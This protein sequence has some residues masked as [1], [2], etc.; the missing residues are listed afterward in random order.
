MNKLLV[1]NQKDRIFNAIVLML[2]F[3]FV[4]PVFLKVEFYNDDYVYKQVAVCGFSEAF[5][6][7]VWHIKNFNGRTL[8]HILAMCFLR[9]DAGVLI[10]KALGATALSAS[11]CLMAKIASC[12]KKNYTFET[13]VV[14]LLFFIIDASAWNQSIYWLTG[15]FNYFV[16]M[17][18]F[19]LLVWITNHKPENKLLY[20]FCIVCGATTEQI[21]MVT[22]GYLFLRAIDELV[23]NK[24]I[25]AKKVTQFVLSVLGY[26]T[27]VFAPGTF[28]R[29]EAQETTVNVSYINNLFVIFQDFL[30]GNISVYILIYPI[31]IISCI[32]IYRYRNTNSLTKKFFKQIIFFAAVLLLF[33]LA[34]KGFSFIA[35]N[36]NFAENILQTIQ[37]VLFIIWL[38][39]VVMFFTTLMLAALLHYRETKNMIPL[40]MLVLGFGSLIMMCVSNKA[41]YRNCMPMFFSLFIFIAYAMRDLLGNFKMREKY[42]KLK[43]KRKLIALSLMV[44][45]L[46]SGLHHMFAAI[47]ALKSG[48]CYINVIN[49]TKIEMLSAEEID[50]FYQE[51]EQA[52]ERYYENPDSGWNKT[53]DS[54]DFLQY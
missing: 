23:K 39:M 9:T 37:P 22:V 48:D 50:I 12:G 40:T 15:S 19:L 52:Y 32:W 6:F 8:M 30:F 3:A 14:T 5:K 1:K 29:V 31:A 33:N 28:G 17:L 43:S 54:K 51:L 49:S 27:V 21:G 47:G 16:P 42:C 38:V 7:I 10:W 53:R 2:V 36:S 24:K 41:F 20:L 18:L 13:I 34:L 45:V 25:C 26:A 44:I 11:I 35:R 4:L 46:L